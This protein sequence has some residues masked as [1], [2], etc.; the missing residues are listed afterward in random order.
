MDRVWISHIKT[1]E[2]EV[3]GDQDLWIAQRNTAMALGWKA[4]LPPEGDGATFFS[5]MLGAGPTWTKSS[6]SSPRLTQQKN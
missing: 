2:V 6:Y 3:K 5:A 1:V 4:T